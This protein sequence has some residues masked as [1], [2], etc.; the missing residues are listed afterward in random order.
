MKAGNSSGDVRSGN[1]NQQQ[2]Q[3]TSNNKIIST[4][5]H[6]KKYKTN[7]DIESA[8]VRLG[9]KGRTDDA[10]HLYHA[11]WTLDR[12]KYQYRTKHSE[13][14]TQNSKEEGRSK[15]VASESNI[16]LQL[17]DKDDGREGTTLPPDL[18]TYV[19]KSKL[20][21]T[22][23]LMNSAIDA[24]ARSH[25]PARQST[26]LDIF[27]CAISPLNREDGTKKAGGALSPNVFTFGS[28]L[29]CCARN[30]D[31][32]ASAE[33]LRVLEAGEEYP[34][35]A[36]NE[37][38]YSTVISACERADVPDVELALEVLNRG[39]RTLYEGSK[40]VV[41]DNKERKM[42]ARTKGTMGV[43]G[44]NAAISAMARSG[45]WK[46][47]VQLLGEM[48][49][50]SRSSPKTPALSR[51]NPNFGPLES[52][53]D[54]LD[55][56]VR[57]L[58]QHTDIAGVTVPKPDGV[59]F[60]TVL[61]ACERAGEWDRLLNVARA[62]TEYGIDLDG[63][64]LTSALHSCQQLGLA[65]EYLVHRGKMASMCEEPF[66]HIIWT[67]VETTTFNIQSLLLL[68][69]SLC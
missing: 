53:R 21:P 40:G 57:P 30:G 42:K 6:L 13:K 34:D 48:I 5:H 62:A 41:V 29:A 61:A 68:T 59:T 7:R 56:P 65:G 51:S 31:I 10:L 35:V 28:L 44:Y 64:A 26:A 66:V 52:I 50:H 33:L 4:L 27:E 16:E 49:L 18:T 2:Q 20:R 32:A 15:S 3:R 45:R 36:L 47:A 37:V 8:I 63:M 19:S 24:C 46:M 58:L 55:D 22:T 43:V 38:L 23:R 1:R 11:V 9:R 14:Q 60:G 67:L 54:N 69:Y 17:F 39:V 25:P 12:L